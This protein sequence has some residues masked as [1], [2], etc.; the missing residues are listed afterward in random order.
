MDVRCCWAIICMIVE[1]SHMHPDQRLNMISLCLRALITISAWAYTR[2]RFIST[3]TWLSYA[4]ECQLT[5]SSENNWFW[6]IS[7]WAWMSHPRQYQ[8]QLIY[9]RRRLVSTRKWLFC[10]TDSQSIL[11]WQYNRCKFISV[12]TSM[13]HSSKYRYWSLPDACVGAPGHNCPIPQTIYL[14]DCERTTEFGLSALVHSCPTF[15]EVY[16]RD[17]RRVTSARVSALGQY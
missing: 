12:R 4:S 2:Y 16:F 14:T 9:I 6:Y 11:L 15:H 17:S 5:V 7:V 13:F 3:W 1:A 8:R 10:S